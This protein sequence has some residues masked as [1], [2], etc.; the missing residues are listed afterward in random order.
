[1]S[2]TK[3]EAMKKHQTRLDKINFV[4]QQEKIKSL[5]K[6]K[7]NT[8]MHAQPKKP[9]TSKGSNSISNYFEN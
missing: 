5:F 9:S 7:L 3:E 6:N 4:N 2:Q 8:Q 1:L